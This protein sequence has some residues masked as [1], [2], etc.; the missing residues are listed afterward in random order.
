MEVEKRNDLESLAIESGADDIRQ[1]WIY[2]KPEDLETVKKTL[3]GKRVKVL[4]AN[5]G[6]SAKEEISADERDNEK[7]QRLFEALDENDAIQDIYSNL[8]N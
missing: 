4:S 5:L 6:W 7:L 2:T 8:K 1:E 3:E